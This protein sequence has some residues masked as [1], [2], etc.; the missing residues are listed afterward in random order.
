[1]ELDGLYVP[2]RAPW[3]PD[4]KAELLALPH[5]RHD[6]IVDALGLVGQ[7]LDKW[8]RGGVP[9]VEPGFFRPPPIDYAALYPRL[10]EPLE[11]SK[12]SELTAG[13]GSGW[14]CV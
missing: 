2:A 3:L 7:L 10:D 5:G 1:M 4:L 14:V 6:D 13:L 12:S 8:A 11:A 9:K